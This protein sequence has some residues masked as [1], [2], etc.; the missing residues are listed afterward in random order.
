MLIRQVTKHLGLVRI[1]S[2]EVDGVVIKGS[3]P[4]KSLLRDPCQ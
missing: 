3:K 2:M 1:E 4:N